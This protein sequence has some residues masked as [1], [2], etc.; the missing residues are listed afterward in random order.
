MIRPVGLGFELSG[1]DEALTAHGGLALMAAYS[2]R[3]GLRA[4]SDLCLPAP[5]SNL[6]YRPF[7]F[8]ESLVLMLQCGGRH[9]EDLRT[10]EGEGALM[11]LIGRASGLRGIVRIARRIKPR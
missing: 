11:S 7:V 2:E 8:V 6:G 9:L 5:G 10:L 1:T 3:L 4:L